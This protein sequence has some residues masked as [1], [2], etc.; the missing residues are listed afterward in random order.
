M[1]FEIDP[2]LL[3]QTDAELNKR[4]FRD[5]ESECD[6]L[7]WEG[8]EGNLNR[9]QFWYQDALLEWHTEQGVKTGHVDRSSGAFTHYQS[10]LYRLHHGLDKEILA[11]V[12]SIIGKK[13]NQEEN[14][15]IKIFEIL[16]D[17]V[18]RD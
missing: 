9:F 1:F 5:A 8:S 4:W 2:D 18:N 16:D 10:E 12:T 3:K 13:T 11:Y 17:I 7:V 6:L 14:I 15:F